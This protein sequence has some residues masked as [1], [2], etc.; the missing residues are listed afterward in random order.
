MAQAVAQSH[1]AC[2]PTLLAGLKGSAFSGNVG[3]QTSSLGRSWPPPEPFPPAQMRQCFF[4]EAGEYVMFPSAADP[5]EMM[6]APQACPLP[7]PESLFC[8]DRAPCSPAALHS[9]EQETSGDGKNSQCSALRQVP[10][11]LL[12]RGASLAA[13]AIPQKPRSPRLE[14]S[15]GGASFTQENI[16]S[17]PGSCG[18]LPP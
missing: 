5:A 11:Q 3:K 13:W 7:W 8:R 10:V 12:P 18:L 6:R 9:T 14:F 16:Q 17:H 4:M 2:R 1:G 15:L